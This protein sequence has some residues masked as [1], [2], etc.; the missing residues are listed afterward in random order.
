MYTK[1]LNFTFSYTVRRTLLPA[2]Q[3]NYY[4]EVVDQINL[5]AT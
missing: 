5:F 4:S 3:L 1:G 2:L